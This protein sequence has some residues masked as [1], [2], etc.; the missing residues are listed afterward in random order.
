[1][2]LLVAIVNCHRRDEWADAIRS[3]WLP[4][5]PEGVDVLFFRGR[6]AKR[7]PHPDE[8]FLDCG[9]EYDDLPDKIREIIRWAY[10]HNYDFVLKCDD[11]VVLDVE[12]L[13]KSGF[14]N[15]DYS[16]KSNRPMTPGR[17]FC[18]PY[19]FCYM[20]SR[21]AMWP[22]INSDLPVGNDDEKWVAETLFNNGIRL[23]NVPRY[24]L[25]LGTLLDKRQEYLRSK[26]KV[27]RPLDHRPRVVEELPEQ[28]AW[29]I[30]LCGPGDRSIT[31]EAKITEFHKV[32]SN[33]IL[34]KKESKQG[35][36]NPSL[37][38]VSVNQG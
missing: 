6:G 37:T 2:K 16:G 26:I 7:L 23:I 14:E 17:P 38:N 10:E 3:T 21:K 36:L 13:M 27:Y 12:M 1:M 25:W 5:K 24:Y 22:V 31:L 28:M 30:Y 4:L 18:V 8:V 33:K 29:C 15:Y 32:F 20:L 11:D 35:N 34:S 9:D 19:G